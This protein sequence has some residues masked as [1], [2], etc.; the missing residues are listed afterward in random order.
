ILLSTISSAVSSNRQHAATQPTVYVNGMTLTQRHPYVYDIKQH[1]VNPIGS[2]NNMLSGVDMNNILSVEIIKDPAR[3]AQL[4]PLAANGA[5]WIQTNDA[6]N[7]RN[8]PE[9]VTL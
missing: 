7:T 5:I 9:K 6:V 3:L 4:G 1:D 8:N 2:A